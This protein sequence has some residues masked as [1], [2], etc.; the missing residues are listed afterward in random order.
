[1]EGETIDS[2]TA[3]KGSRFE[4]VGQR[5]R[6]AQQTALSALGSVPGWVWIVIAGVIL[7]FVGLMAANQI[8]HRYQPHPDHG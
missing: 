6:E 8:R 3:P 7:L 1:M 2:D 4:N 5:A